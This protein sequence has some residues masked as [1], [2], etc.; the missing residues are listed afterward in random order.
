MDS[1][2]QGNRPARIGAKEKSAMHRHKWYAAVG[3]AAVASGQPAVAGLYSGPHDTAHLV[4]PAMPSSS[5]RFVGWAN[6][7]DPSRTYFAPRGSTTISNTG[8]NSLGDLDATQI[9]SGAS[10]GYLTVT[11]PIPVRNG[12]GHDF[13][14][15][16]N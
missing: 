16:E 13:A 7:I 15:F 10:P 14:V 5:P 11:F 12:A 4:D 1:R 8:F 6:A 3:M 9:A 2:H